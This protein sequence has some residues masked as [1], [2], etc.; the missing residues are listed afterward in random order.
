MQ[1]FESRA[2]DTAWVFVL[3]AGGYGA[4]CPGIAFAIWIAAGVAMVYHPVEFL[5]AHM[6]H[7]SYEHVEAGYQEL[8]QGIVRDLSCC[9]I[10]CLHREIVNFEVRVHAWNFGRKT[11][12]GA[13]FCCG[14]GRYE[15]D[16]QW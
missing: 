14:I 5:P 6:C 8:C 10:V 15:R 4:D 13:E 7:Y 3:C 2:A 12:C 16:V 1:G 9:G 11:E